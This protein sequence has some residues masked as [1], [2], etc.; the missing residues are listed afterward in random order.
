MAMFLLAQQLATK[1]AEHALRNE[2]G[3]LNDRNL[4]DIGL[5]R[6]GIK[7]FARAATWPVS[8]TSPRRFSCWH[9]VLIGRAQGL[10]SV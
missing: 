5:E 6:A 10:R 4:A 1:L 2:L 3:R 8:S 9:A 7:Q